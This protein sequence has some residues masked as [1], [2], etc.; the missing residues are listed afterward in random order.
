MDKAN[1]LAQLW[2]DPEVP[3][4]LRVELLDRELVVQPNPGHVHDLPGRSLVR[5]TP[6]PFEARSKRG[7]LVADD[8]RPRADAVI[9]G[10]DRPADES[11]ADW[12]TQV[13][14]AVV[15]TVSSTRTAIKP[16]WEDKR[17]RYAAVGIPVYLIVDPND[18]TWHVLQLE[19]RVYVETG[20]GIFGQP[21]TLPEPMGFTVQT[22]SWH[23]YSRTSPEPHRG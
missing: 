23:P 15:E 20:K 10:E 14:L 1:A 18:A 11:D 22:H 16:E 12:P 21:L 3:D 2:H 13:V 6:E 19:S 17:E 7:L 4:G 5:H 8:Y 9:R